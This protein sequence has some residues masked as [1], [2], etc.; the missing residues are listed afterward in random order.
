MG[1]SS[2][3]TTAGTAGGQGHWPARYAA[4][5]PRS[6]AL[7]VAH[8]VLFKPKPGLDAAARQR[9]AD[10]FQNAI[11]IIPSIR[12][13]HIGR[14]VKIGRPYEQLMAV[15]YE[16]AAVLEFDS[17]ADLKSY[18]EHPAHDALGAGFFEAFETALMYDYEMREGESGVA[19]LV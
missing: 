3:W 8:V 19:A 2:A 13:A 4:R 5:S 17:A 12:R 18:L 9:L 14:R 11:R 7:M 6:Q 1:R 16:F 10:V 15:D